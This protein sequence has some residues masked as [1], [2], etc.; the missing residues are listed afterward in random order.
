MH[1]KRRETEVQ[2]MHTYTNL[3]ATRAMTVCEC[4]I[5]VSPISP[6]LTDIHENCITN[7]TMCTYTYATLQTFRLHTPS[8]LQQ[9][10]L[11]K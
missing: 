8:H 11:S 9:G 7:L 1:V 2:V 4:T 6:V 5:H 10:K 3:K